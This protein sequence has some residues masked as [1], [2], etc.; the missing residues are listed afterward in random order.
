M[1]VNGFSLLQV[2]T[3]IDLDLIESAAH[4]EQKLRA[5]Q[6][7]ARHPVHRFR[8]KRLL[9][10]LIAII[11]ALILTGACAVTIIYGDLWLQK[12]ARDPIAVVMSALE[13]QSGKDYTLS[14]EIISVEP[15]L[16]ETVRMKRYICDSAVPEWRGW[17][18]E[19][20]AENF[21]AVKAVYH[22]VYDQTK[23]TRS[24]GDVTQYFYL[25]RGSDNKLWTII[26]NSGNLNLLDDTSGAPLTPNTAN[27]REQL[28]LYL[29]E[30]FN[31][32]YSLYYDG[33]RYEINDYS[34]IISN[35][36]FTA[37]F[38]F[39]M[40]HLAKGW[41]IESDEGKEQEGNF[42]LVVKA[43]INPDGSLDFDSISVFA[44]IDWSRDTDDLVPIEEFF[45]PT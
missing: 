27:P 24:D 30:L 7:N 35:S 3:D 18:C 36:Q 29:S 44:D 37:D 5:A 41:D 22:A 26:D 15:D 38:R 14:I 43:N 12:P 1:D 9:I 16:D 33:L 42:F 40:Y 6:N 20:L 23:T 19:Y 45:P 8:R 2:L 39:T 11:S 17:S 28:L 31:R 21:I 10:A 13:S 32:A 34:E 4:N 25:T